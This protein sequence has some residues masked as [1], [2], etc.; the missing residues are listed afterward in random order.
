MKN[1]IENAYR[2]LK[3][4]S[5]YDNKNIYLKKRIVEFEKKNRYSLNQYDAAF[6]RIEEII[7]L[8]IKEGK[9]IEEYLKEDESELEIRTL[10]KS[11][12]YDNDKSNIVDNTIDNKLC[13]INKI[14]HFLDASIEVQILGV[15]WIMLV[16]E[17]VEET[18]KKYTAGNILES[19]F[20]NSNLK[21]FRPYH[22]QYQRWRDDGV[23]EVENRMKE[24]KRTIMMSLDIKEYFYSV[25]LG[26]K[27]CFTKEFE[28]IFK[29]KKKKCESTEKFNKINEFIYYV[30]KEYSSKLLGKETNRTI[31]PIGFLPSF[32]L[33]NWYLNDFDK[34]IVKEINP[35]YYKRYVDDIIIVLNADNI[36][37]KVIKEE[38][39]FKNIF[40]EK[41]ILKPGIIFNNNEKIY[42][43]YKK[44][45]IGEEI[46]RFLYKIPRNEIKIKLDILNYIEEI[47]KDDEFIE[48]EKL[49]KLNHIL[50]NKCE[51]A[52]KNWKEDN[53]DIKD[54]F[55]IINSLENLKEMI[56]EELILNIK[57]KSENMKKVYCINKYLNGSIDYYYGEKDNE[58]KMCIHDEKIKIYDFKPDGSN[59]IIENFK[60]ELKDNA[61]VFKFLPEKNM[62][63]KSFDS[64]VYKIDYKDNIY[65]LSN[66]DKVNINRYNLSKFLARV[67]YSDKLENSKY[68]KDVDEKIL[69]LFKG[70]A[71]IEYYS[72][73]DKVFNYYLLN[74]N[75]KYIKDI[76]INIYSSIERINIEID[77][78]TL[79]IDR[80]TYNT[81]NILKNKLKTDLKEY[82]NIVI[83][84]NYA[85]S[86]GLFSEIIKFENKNTK[87]I[88]YDNIINQRIYKA[89]VNCKDIEAHIYNDTF[90]NIYTLKENIR[91][92]NMLNHAL[93]RQPLMNYC[94]LKDNMSEEER[95]NTNFI[96]DLILTPEINSDMR[97][98]K[99]NKNYVRSFL[100]PS[101][102]NHE[103]EKLCNCKSEIGS[104]SAKFNPRFVHLHECILYEINKNISEGKIIQAGNE[105]DKGFELFNRINNIT[106]KKGEENEEYYIN[107][108]SNINRGEELKTVNNFNNTHL[109]YFDKDDYLFLQKDTNINYIEVN[110]REKKEKIKIG[111]INMNVN[112]MDLKKSFNKLSNL[113]SKR[114]ENL[115]KL[116]NDAVKNKSEI[117]VFPEVSIPIQWLGIIANFSKKHDV[118]IICGLEHII[119]ENGLCCNYIATV[120][121]DKYEKYSNSI[122]KLRLKNYY[123][124]NEKEWVNG[125]G[126]KLP[127]DEDKKFKKEYDLFRWKGVD[128]STFSCF[129]LAN[130]K[131]RSLFIS[132]VDLLIGSVHNK[133]V[134][135]YSNVIESL[136]R[137]VHCYFAH[138]NNSSMGDN[139]IIKPAATNQ[140][141]ILQI[142]GGLNDTVLV[143]EIDIKDLRRFQQL[144]HNLQ[145]K[146]KSFKAVPPEFNYN[147]VKI[148]NGIPL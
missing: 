142:S 71:S 141:N 4:Y 81:G 47:T 61:S 99:L 140:K 67:I 53:E 6:E 21:L 36:D 115:Y 41:K 139:R 91:K 84:M 16:G 87:P 105:M 68:T 137:D 145:M 19:N 122:I 7:Q 133:D 18:Y 83:A 134:N 8:A 96:H 12:I 54:L 45:Y 20:S 15:L 74:N 124:P 97:C 80:F 5:Y 100:L 62:V 73:W 118:A 130:I 79:N 132:Y 57:I 92:A 38:E 33:G 37:D 131:D 46:E 51:I 24:N 52:Y 29:K 2:K 127:G 95:S 27:V 129:E 128:F 144:E 42:N 31:L 111:I 108:I 90:N 106:G 109:K 11:L 119:Y 76:F 30:I 107:I 120:L 66:I 58:S 104:V 59:A 32:I 89:L 110:K 136:A 148:R 26:S 17:E 3:S 75:Y 82:L 146:D 88:E 23:K 9:G 98:Y 125:Y 50:K 138:V 117:I 116:L 86:D 44:I 69:W 64:E 121:P 135:Y 123:S 103:D 49:D 85:L 22:I 43:K 25:N 65:K 101:E 60:K 72:L 126:W 114:L 56:E 14:I 143:G 63:V 35:L 1:L 28:K 102:Y 39:L 34:E 48:R 70:A 113:E 93:I 55:K 78:F 112:D 10:P 13:K 147:N 94:Y 77:N 40:C